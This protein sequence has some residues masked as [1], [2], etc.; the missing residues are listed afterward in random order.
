MPR[1]AAIR[2]TS[3]TARTSKVG[4]KTESCSKVKSL[5]AAPRVAESK[6]AE[7]RVSADSLI[8]TSQLGVQSII[9]TEGEITSTT[10]IAITHGEG[11]TTSIT[12][13]ICKTHLM[14]LRGAPRVPRAA[15]TN[16]GR[17]YQVREYLSLLRS[18]DSRFNRSASASSSGA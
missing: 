1:E 14:S 8:T 11:E 10:T 5:F 16:L 2:H 6:I 9:A 15:D 4:R 17:I 7:R 13:S 3:Q 18:R 12:G